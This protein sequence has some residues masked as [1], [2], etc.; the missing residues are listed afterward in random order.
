MCHETNNSYDHHHLPVVNAQDENGKMALMW[1]S[2]DGHSQV[3]KLL[4]A[5]E[6]IQVNLPSTYGSDVSVQYGHSQV[7]KQRW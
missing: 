1:A 6:G 2:M 5:K 4:L 7:V 3:V